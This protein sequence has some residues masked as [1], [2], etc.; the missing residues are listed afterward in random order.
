P[1]SDIFFGQNVGGFSADY[2]LTWYVAI[3]GITFSDRKGIMYYKA[4]ATTKDVSGLTRIEHITDG[5]TTTVIV[6]YPPPSPNGAYLP[7]YWCWW[8]YETDTDTSMSANDNSL[9][10]SGSNGSGGTTCPS[11]DRFRQGN[12]NNYCDTHHFWSTPFN[13][14]Q[15]AF[16]DGN[17]N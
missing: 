9:V 13:G 12:I 1:R 5:T 6:E 4:P 7:L 17:V 10:F 11:P 3:T 14:A 8:L 16:V 2:G 15:F